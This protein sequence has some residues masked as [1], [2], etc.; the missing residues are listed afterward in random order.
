MNFKI[1]ICTTIIDMNFFV[2]NYFF[3]FIS[4]YYIDA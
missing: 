4:L 1:F 2:H 3:C